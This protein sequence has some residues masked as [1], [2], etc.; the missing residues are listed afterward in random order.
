M[1]VAVLAGLV[2]VFAILAFLY[3]MTTRMRK[4]ANI[5]LQADENRFVVELHGWDAFFC[6]RRRV[7]VPLDEVDG[8]GVYPRERVPAQGLR[9]PGTSLPGAIRAGS[10]GFRSAPDFWDVRKA[11][12]VLVVAL[13]PEPSK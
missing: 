4:P 5:S 3:V 8:V 10:F 7:E 13:K 1:N 11:K 6:C 9:W 12:E 2:P